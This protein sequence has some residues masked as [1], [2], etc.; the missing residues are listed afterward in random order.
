MSLIK[1]IKSGK[2]HRKHYY[3]SRRF[4]KSCRCHGGCPYCLGNR[5]HNR[6]KT[7]EDSKLKIR[8]AED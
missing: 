4:D 8:E 2:E 3:D 1:A 5:L 6:R 7:D